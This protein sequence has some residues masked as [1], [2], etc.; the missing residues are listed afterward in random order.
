MAKNVKTSM[1]ESNLVQKK[2]NRIRQTSLPAV[3]HERIKFDSYS[4]RIEKFRDTLFPLPDFDKVKQGLISTS[5]I[6]GSVS[7]P[8]L[9]KI[10]SGVAFAL[11]SG[12]CWAVPSIRPLEA[13][14]N[15]LTLKSMENFLKKMIE[16][17]Y[18]NERPKSEKEMKSDIKKRF[19]SNISNL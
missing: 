14:H 3:I 19:K 8:S 5:V 4:E 16:S 2:R 11:T 7:A 12:N 17:R 6:S 15:S 9:S 10:E 1:S 18:T 13:M